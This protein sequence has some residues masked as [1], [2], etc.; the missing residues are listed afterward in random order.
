M[1][2]Q[3]VYTDKGP[4]AIGPYSQAIVAQGSFIFVSGQIGILPDT[5]EF[6]DT[7]VEGQ[8]KQ[9]LNNIKAILEAG[10]S[11][12]K[13]VVKTTVLLHRIEDFAALNAI[14]ATFFT[15]NPP[16]RA[17]FGGL[18]LPKGALVEIECVALIEN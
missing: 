4:K 6:A 7:T 14:Y 5:G 9:A 12:L 18:D 17:T 11:G 3:V 2:R 1:S 8:A 13:N 15:E 16:A 10:G